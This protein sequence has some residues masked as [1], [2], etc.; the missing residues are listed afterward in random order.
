MRLVCTLLQV[1]IAFTHVAEAGPEDALATRYSK[2]QTAHARVTPSSGALVVGML[3][4][5]TDG[6]SS[7]IRFKTISSAIA[8]LDQHTTTVQTIFIG[9]GTYNEQVYVPPLK[10]PLIIQGYTCDARTYDGNTVTLRHSLSLGQLQDQNSTA[11]NDDNTATLRLWTAAGLRLYNINIENNFSPHPPSG[12]QALAVSASP[13]STGGI[14]FYACQFSGYQDTLL[15]D[16]GTQ[17]YVG[18]RIQGAVDFVFGRMA[19]AWFE[20]CDVRVTGPGHITASG[21]SSSDSSSWYVFNNGTVDVDESVSDSKSLTHKTYLGRP[22]AEYARVVFQHTYLGSVVNPAG[23]AP[24]SKTPEN[25]NTGHVYFGEYGNTGPS[26]DLSQRAAFSKQLSAP[27]DMATVLGTS[28]ASQW[29][30]DKAS[31]VT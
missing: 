9:P 1:I 22:W 8:A 14:G 28:W 16:T 30:A 7:T 3:D 18:C 19:R 2:S 26:S 6:S 13:L 27:V 17:L 24:W 12:G 11:A 23:W 31:Y 10:G 15:A 20:R 5:A 25:S 29:W 21:R 4:T